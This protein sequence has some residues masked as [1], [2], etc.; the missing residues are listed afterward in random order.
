MKIHTSLIKLL[1]SVLAPLA[2]T[3]SSVSQLQAAE[4]I[5]NSTYTGDTILGVTKT[6]NDDGT[7]VVESN[8]VT[9]NGYNQSKAI[10]GARAYDNCPVLENNSV[11]ITGSNMGGVY[12]VDHTD[13]ANNPA[14]LRNNTISISDSTL[15]SAVTGVST[16]TRGEGTA[17]NNNTVKITNSTL[18]NGLTGAAPTYGDANYNTVIVEGKSF[19][20]RQ[21]RGANV[22]IGDVA[23]NTVILNCVTDDT[24]TATQSGYYA[25][26]YGATT[27]QGN[28][29]DNTL[30]V[31]GSTFINR[32][33]NNV[34]GAALVGGQ[35]A[36]GTASGNSVT[37]SENAKIVGCIYGGWQSAFKNDVLTPAAIANTVTVK[38]NAVVT[39]TI[40]AGYSNNGDATGNIVE[41]DGGTVSGAIYGGYVVAAGTKA[42]GNTVILNNAT[43]DLSGARIYGGGGSASAG[44]LVTGNMLVLN[45]CKDTVE[46]IYNFETIE[47][48]IGT[49]VELA[50]IDL[51]TLNQS[52]PE[53]FLTITGTD[54]DLSG[55]TINLIFDSEEALDAMAGEHFEL[56]AGDVGLE[57]TKSFNVL[58]KDGKDL[59]DQV[60]ITNTAGGLALDVTPAVPE[61][62]TASLSLLGLAALMMRRRRA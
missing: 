53:A 48:H 16:T 49:P 19:V 23:N 57:G 44:D 10:Y 36:Y 8:T 17:A 61:P 6:T 28:A 18:K 35:S 5:I 2:C 52:E 54:T 56:I 33:E 26:T 51:L 29:I 55:V 1:T 25:V 30:E 7:I 59:S 38:D 58:T 22:S 21:I 41:I 42:T 20:Q 40:Y 9:V 62:A 45:G 15:S 39:G 13:S 34:T 32:G 37:V 31:K 3:L 11:T 24:L 4:Y 50:G 60:C 14:V 47:I 12:G 46:G 27:S 43:G